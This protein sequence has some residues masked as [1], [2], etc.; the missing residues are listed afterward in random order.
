MREKQLQV[1]S[2]GLKLQG[3][4]NTPDTD[5]WP[6]VVL[7][8][9]FLSH[10]DSSKYK[11]LAQVFA[12][13]GIGTIRFDFRGCGESEGYLSESAVSGRWLDL[14]RVIDGVGVLAGFNGR[15]GLMGSSLGGYLALLEA[16]RNLQVC[17]VVIWSTPSHLQELAER[18]PEV[19]PVEMSRESYEDLRRVEVLSRLETV[20]RVLIVHGQKD[21]QVPAEHASKLLAALKQPKALHLLKNGDHRLSQA[22]VREEAIRLSLDWF[23]R[24][25]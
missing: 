3:V 21:R 10:K 14:Q 20:E 7:C 17:C 16:S 13:E 23:R 12:R 2:D 5:T 8:H 1:F 15:L 25:L 24:F 19:A 4:L 9:G 22:E 11:Q 18:L 6:L